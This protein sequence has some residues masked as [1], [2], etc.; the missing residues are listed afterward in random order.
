MKPSLRGQRLVAVLVQRELDAHAAGLAVDDAGQLAHVVDHLPQ[1]RA[2]LVDEPVHA[3]RGVEQDR[4]LHG[5]LHV[6]ARQ[7]GRPGAACFGVVDDCAGGD[8]GVLLSRRGVRDS[9]GAAERS[10]RVRL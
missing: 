6:V 8:D 2:R 10:N 3:A 9:G 5:V 4:D 1:V 7:L